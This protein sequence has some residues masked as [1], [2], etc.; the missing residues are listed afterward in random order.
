MLT[1]GNPTARSKV[2]KSIVSC[3]DWNLRRGDS[4]RVGS[5]AGAE[6]TSRGAC[7]QGAGCRAP[8]RVSSRQQHQPPARSSPPPPH[9]H[10]PPC[11]PTALPLPT[12]GPSRGRPLPSTCRAEPTQP[13]SG[14]APAPGS[15]RPPMIPLLSRHPREHHG[16]RRGAVHPAISC[17]ASMRTPKGW[18]VSAAWTAQASL[19]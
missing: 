14:A 1:K 16:H 13:A 4:A 15:L 11:R 9:L 8:G 12:A 17:S 3:R 5:S 6:S 10:L 18:E 7:V 19:A 2:Q